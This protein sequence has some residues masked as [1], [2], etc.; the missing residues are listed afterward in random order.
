MKKITTLFLFIAICFSFSFAQIS[1]EDRSMTQGVNT[2]LIMSIPN[3][4]DKSTEK[5]WKKYMKSNGAKTKKIKKSEEYLSD[6]AKIAGVGGGNTV[7]VY[8]TF[9]QS[10]DNVTMTTWVD[11]G[12][13]YLNNEDH[14]EKYSA[15]ETFLSEFETHVYKEGVKIEIKSE[16]NNL[17]KLNSEMKKLKKDNDKYHK[18]IADSKKKIERAEKD[19][20]ENLQEQEDA[21]SRIEV[22]QEVVEKTKK[23]LE[24]R[25]DN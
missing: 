4:D 12:G 14:P 24:V 11:L 18:I 8:A 21:S 22:Q 10:G 16:E 23:K 17:K 1:Q 7:D 2:A 3:A 20:E 25:E 19:I 15:C 9:E 5:L 13:A 6:D